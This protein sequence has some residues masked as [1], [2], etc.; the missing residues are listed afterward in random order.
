M[1]TVGTRHFEYTP[2]GIA[3]ASAYSE[4]T[5]LPVIAEDNAPAGGG[6][7]SDTLESTLP[8]MSPEGIE[9]ENIPSYDAGGRVKT[10]QGYGEGGK[11]KK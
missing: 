3:E 11:V 5:G 4:E 1:P 7:L 2:D 8:S 10:I 9:R 6:M